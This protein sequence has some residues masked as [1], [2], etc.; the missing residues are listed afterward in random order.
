MTFSQTAL[1][2]TKW[3]KISGKLQLTGQNRNLYYKTL[4]IHNER[5]MDKIT[6]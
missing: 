2:E 3:A 4:Q 6:H 1:N 5:K